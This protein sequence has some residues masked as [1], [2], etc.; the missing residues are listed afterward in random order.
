MAAPDRMRFAMED[1]PIEGVPVEAFE[2][3]DENLTIE[4]WAR[5]PL[6]YSPVAMDF[7]AQGRLWLTEGIDY[8]RGLRIEEGRSIMVLEDQDGDGEADSSHVFVT[9]KEIRHAPLGIAVFDNRT[10]LFFW[11]QHSHRLE[12][13]V[14]VQQIVERNGFSA[15][16]IHVAQR[17]FCT[18]FSIIQSFLM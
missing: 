11:V 17:L 8:Q 2:L 14:D 7:D 10:S 5:S 1:R 4:L 18:I 6:I 13:T 12:S 9:E 3:I 15:Q 16:N